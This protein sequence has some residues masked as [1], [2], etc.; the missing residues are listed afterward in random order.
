MA[1]PPGQTLTARVERIV[2]T[3]PLAC[4]TLGCDPPLAALMFHRDIDRLRLAAGTTVHIGLPPGSFR[5][6]Q[7][8]AER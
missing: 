5:I 3:R 7:A 2:R 1:A 8:R 6:F 4:I